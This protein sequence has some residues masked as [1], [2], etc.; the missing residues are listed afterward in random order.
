MAGDYPGI[1]PDEAQERLGDGPA[2]FLHD[3]SMLP[4]LNLR[5]FVIDV[6]RKAEIPLQFNVLSGYGQ[7]G[8]AMQRSR[9]GAPV[10]NITVPTRYL[11]SHNG[12][13]SRDDFANA[14]RL[15]T[16]VVRRLA[17]A[18]VQRIRSFD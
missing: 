10:V 6:A 11:H 15:V 18:T 8:S 5:N 17:E 1:S 4:N 9:T 3:S 2:I 13:I 7:D 12:I 16:E 14:V